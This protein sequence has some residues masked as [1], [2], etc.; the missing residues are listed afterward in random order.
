[1]SI[2]TYS[3][4]SSSGVSGWESRTGEFKDIVDANEV[5][6]ATEQQVPG[7]FM[8]E[9]LYSIL[10]MLLLYNGDHSSL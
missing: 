2:G 3:G 4:F 6:T 9:K 5:S 10:A 7:K 8:E 1:M